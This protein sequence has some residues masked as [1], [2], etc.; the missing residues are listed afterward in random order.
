MELVLKIQIAKEGGTFIAYAPELD[1]SSCGHT[2]MEA[3][4]NLQ[5][6]VQLFIE[7]AREHG[8]LEEILEESGFI[9][10][11]DSILEGPEI[12]SRNSMQFPLPALVASN[13]QAG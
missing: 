13:H 12:V 7:T 3:E 11:H 10:K 6:A 8:T 2:L 5:E 4:K 9:K 1:I